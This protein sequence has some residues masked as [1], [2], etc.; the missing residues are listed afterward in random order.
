M[1]SIFI[2]LN[3]KGGKCVLKIERIKST[4]MSYEFEKKAT[5]SN[6]TKKLWKYVIEQ[7]WKEQGFLSARDFHPLYT[8]SKSSPDR[9]PAESSFLPLNIKGSTLSFHTKFHGT[10]ITWETKIC[11]QS[12][13][14]S[15]GVTWTERR[16]LRSGFTYAFR[17]LKMIDFNWAL[18]HK[19]I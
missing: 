7:D 1:Q 9:Q 19:R 18:I 10:K 14:R 2:L 11:W 13:W 4:V 12:S 16:R 8:C 15:P 17:S 5:K 6:Q 3:K